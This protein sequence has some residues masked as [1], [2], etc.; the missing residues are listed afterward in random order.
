[1][2]KNQIATSG[3]VKME[4]YYLSL[5]NIVSDVFFY[6]FPVHGKRDWYRDGSR[7]LTSRM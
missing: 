4:I 3:F 6:H 7:R 2:A 1:V 5:N